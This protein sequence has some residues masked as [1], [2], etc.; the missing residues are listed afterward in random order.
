MNKVTILITIT[1]HIYDC[2]DPKNRNNSKKRY[3][4]ELRILRLTLESS[5]EKYHCAI[6]PL[7]TY[8]CASTIA[9]ADHNIVRIA[10]A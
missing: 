6:V 5:F 9:A 7:I 10:N 4:K 2:V 8:T 1:Y 3:L